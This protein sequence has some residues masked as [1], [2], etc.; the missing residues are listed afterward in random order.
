MLDLLQELGTRGVAPQSQAV[1]HHTDRAHRHRRRRHRGGEPETERRV[2]HAGGDRDADHVV[3]ERPEEI[4]TDDPHGPPGERD[5][6]DHSDGVAAHERDCRRLPSPRRS[7][8]PS[9]FRRRPGR[10]PARRSVRRP[11][12][13]RR[14]L[15]P[16]SPG[17]P[18][19]SDRAV[20]RPRTRRT[21]TVAGHAL[22]VRRSSPVSMTVSIP[23]CSSARH[24]VRAAG[25]D[26]IGH[27]DEPGDPRHPRRRIPASG[28]RP[29]RRRPRLSSASDSTSRS[30]MQ[31][32]VAH[33]DPMTLHDR[34]HALARSA[35]KGLRLGNPQLPL[36]ARQRRRPRPADA[37]SSSRPRQPGQ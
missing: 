4:L 21:P 23:S 28:H 22:G 8:P 25:L 13:P 35:A 20:P 14:V 2:Q 33:A 27:G 15:R 32:D 24:R 19:A 11:P 3:D 10:A 17:S 9:R 18:R 30:R 16:E 29:R 12:S 37:R 36:F 26:R 7:R 6:G 31:R 34:H 1:H 5:R